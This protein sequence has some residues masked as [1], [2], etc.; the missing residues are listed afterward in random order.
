M[1]CACIW[2]KSPTFAVAVV[3]KTIK[4]YNYG[5]NQDS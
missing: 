4:Q 1:V 5:S 2:K 3:L